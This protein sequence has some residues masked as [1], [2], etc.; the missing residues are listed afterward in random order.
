LSRVIKGASGRIY[1]EDVLSDVL[2][3]DFC[4]FLT[5]AAYETTDEGLFTE[6]MCLT[7]DA[8]GIVD[9]MVERI[10][11]IQERAKIEQ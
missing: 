11:G 7:S 6:Y 3:Q 8:R 1:D 5:A 4:G 2:F 10:R 9:R